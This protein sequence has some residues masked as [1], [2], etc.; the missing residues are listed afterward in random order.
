[1]ADRLTD[2]I[3]AVVDSFLTLLSSIRS[4]LGNTWNALRTF[5]SDL[6]SAL[7][8]ALGCN[9]NGVGGV[10]LVDRLRYSLAL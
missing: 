9:G 7:R 3:R 1:M 8:G 6:E 5:F 2:A 10:R 4:G